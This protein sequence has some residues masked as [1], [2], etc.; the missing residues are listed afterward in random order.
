MFGTTSPF[1]P[2]HAVGRNRHRS[3]RCSNRLRFNRHIFWQHPVV[4]HAGM[5]SRHKRH[6]HRVGSHAP[7]RLGTP[8]QI[9]MIPG[10]KRITEQAA[11]PEP[12]IQVEAFKPLQTRI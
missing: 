12:S 10:W 6:A 5:D 11:S 7:A 2:H 1:E 9:P 4:D 3:S 8:L